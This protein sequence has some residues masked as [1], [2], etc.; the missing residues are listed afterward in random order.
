[1]PTKPKL[2][3]RCALPSKLQRSRSRFRY[4]NAQKQPTQNTVAK[5]RAGQ[6]DAGSVCLFANRAG[7]ADDLPAH[8]AR[9]LTAGVRIVCD[10]VKSLKD[11]NEAASKHQ[12]RLPRR[13]QSPS[14]FDSHVQY[15]VT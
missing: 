10:I 12:S 5:K 15:I 7:V 8:V 2:R 9:S 1:M 13:R 3:L 14:A 11:A 6:E 4:R